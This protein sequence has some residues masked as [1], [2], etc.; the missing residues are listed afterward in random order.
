M[1]LEMEKENAVPRL[2][3]EKEESSCMLDNFHYKATLN[4]ILLFS[5][6]EGLQDSSHYC[7]RSG[8]PL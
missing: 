5:W 2:W 8:F 7:N 6:G 1:E 4:D 3:K